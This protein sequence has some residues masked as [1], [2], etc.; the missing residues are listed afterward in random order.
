[1]FVQQRAIGVAVAAGDSD[2]CGNGGGGPGGTG[3][4][5]FDDWVGG[6]ERRLTIILFR[7]AS[8]IDGTQS[9]G[10]ARS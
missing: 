7:S 2:G 6:T 8:A 1:M 9:D 10:T 5:M 3:A 4:R